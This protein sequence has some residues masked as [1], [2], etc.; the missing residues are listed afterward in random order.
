MRIAWSFFVL[1]QTFSA[2]DRDQSGKIPVEEFRRV[3][4]LF[5]FKMTSE[6]WRKIKAALHIGSDNCVEY[7][8]FLDSF[9]GSE[10]IENTVWFY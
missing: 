6:Q 4:D 5:C 1:L 10:V 2:I 7:M 8:S 3:L 9:V